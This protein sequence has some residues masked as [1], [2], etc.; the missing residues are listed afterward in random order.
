MDKL[1]HFVYGKIAGPSLVPGDYRVLALYP[2][3][4]GQ[5]SAYRRLAEQK[6]DPLLGILEDSW[7]PDHV[8]EVLFQASKGTW[9]YCHVFYVGLYT[10][11]TYSSYHAVLLSSK[12]LHFLHYRPWELLRCLA[13]EIR[14]NELMLGDGRRFALT[15][16]A[17]ELPLILPKAPLVRMEMKSTGD[18][19]L[20]HIDQM[21]SQRIRIVLG[22][23]R[24]NTPPLLSSMLRRRIESGRSTGYV[25]GI[26]TDRLQPIRRTL[27]KIGGIDF[28]WLRPGESGHSLS[29]GYL[30]IPDGRE[31]K[32]N[33][34]ESGSSLN[35]DSEVLQPSDASCTTT[36]EDSHAPS[37][38]G[39]KT[40]TEEAI[41]ASVCNESA[42]ES[43]VKSAKNV[44]GETS[45]PSRYVPLKSTSKSKSHS[46]PASTEGEKDFRSMQSSTLADR[47]SPVSGNLA[48]STPGHR[49][50][51]VSVVF[52]AVAVLVVTWVLYDD[53]QLTSKEIPDTATAV[54]YQHGDLHEVEGKPANIA[55]SDMT[56]V[57]AQEMY[58]TLLLKL[59]VLHAAIQEVQLSKVASTLGDGRSAE[60]DRMS[61]LVRALMIDMC[62]VD[63]FPEPKRLSKVEEK[64]HHVIGNLGALQEDKEQ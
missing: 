55:G 16:T 24:D 64:L 46:V 1:N 43:N 12:Q 51:L 52:N 9:L 49:W 59:H 60:L 50:L 30:G 57:M 8:T 17:L 63:G 20:E 25:R 34:V 31:S 22:S 19:R 47:A 56:A 6:L 13:S 42:T 38:I 23:G 53:V 3:T 15:E 21:L 58:Q 40:R 35:S 18:D 10:G 37:C 39:Q 14:N 33:P 5:R 28:V 36:D 62:S 4:E 45:F 26:S 48:V 54:H 27:D 2:D 11:R 32:Q 29:P 61:A 44:S 7:H 41:T